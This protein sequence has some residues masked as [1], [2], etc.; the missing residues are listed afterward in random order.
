MGWWWLSLLL[1][2]SSSLLLSKNITKL[3]PP[4]SISSTSPTTIKQPC[5]AAVNPENPCNLF[6]P[7]KAKIDWENGKE[8]WLIGGCS[9]H[10][11][12]ASGTWKCSKNEAA[13]CL[14]ATSSLITCKSLTEIQ[15]GWSLISP[16]KLSVSVHS[17]VASGIKRSAIHQVANICRIDWRW[18]FRARRMRIRSNGLLKKSRNRRIVGTCHWHCLQSTQLSLPSKPRDRMV[19]G[20]ACLVHWRAIWQV[21]HIVHKQST[22]QGRTWRPVQSRK[23][24]NPLRLENEQMSPEKGPF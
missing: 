16:Q 7:W 14:A 24:K 18:Q 19:D 4:T 20:I 21:A 1:L 2:F 15:P 8:K 11:T 3:D 17:V 9:S 10:S 23:R 5:L 12:L 22:G 6:S 13:S